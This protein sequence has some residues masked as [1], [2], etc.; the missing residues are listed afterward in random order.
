MTAPVVEVG[1]DGRVGDW[2]QVASGIAFYPFDPRPEDIRIEDIA[3]ALALQ[4]RFGGHTREFYSVAQHSLHVSE[5]VS[6]PRALAALLHDA[7]EAYL[8][9]VP[10][11][12]KRGP[13]FAMYCAL[14]R[15][16]TNAIAKRF[17]LPIDFDL[18]EEIAHADNVLLAT[19]KRD[20]LVESAKP[21]LPLPAPLPRILSPWP[22]RDAEIAF[23]SRFGQLTA[24]LNAKGASAA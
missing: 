5:N 11:P 24:Q 20:L 14:E 19:E 17:G 13:G 2:C 23:L 6:A 1:S 3:H 16:I 21:W 8:V 9:D 18:G 12:L 7:A 4:C 22:W 10:R 15:V